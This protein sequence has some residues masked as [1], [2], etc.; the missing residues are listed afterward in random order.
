MH[1][2]EMTR[3]EEKDREERFD[4]LVNG[5]VEKQYAKRDMKKEREKEARHALLQNV[6]TTRK[7]QMRHR[8][9]LIEIYWFL[10]KESFAAQNLFLKYKSRL[11]Q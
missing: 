1:Y 3:K 4:K 9:Q 6:L 8:G 2:M 5:E 11:I 10:G 7:E